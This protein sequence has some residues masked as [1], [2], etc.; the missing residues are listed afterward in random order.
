MEKTCTQCGK[1]Y[2]AK[3]EL[4]KFCSSACRQKN[5]RNNVT[6]DVTKI[7]KE[8]EEL[9]NTLSETELEAAA[10]LKEL[11]ILDF[12]RDTLNKQ[13]DKLHEL[14]PELWAKLPKKLSWLLFH[15]FLAKHKIT[16]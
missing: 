15:K 10:L 7:K 9:R 12:S 8:N 4:S 16:L 5:Y 14:H 11:E 3:Q 1:K 2:N 13:T 6:K